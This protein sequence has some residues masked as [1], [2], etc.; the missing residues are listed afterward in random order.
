M[1]SVSLAS[2]RFE[3]GPSY[4]YNASDAGQLVDTMFNPEPTTRYVNMLPGV[5]ATDEEVQQ[6]AAAGLVRLAVSE[7]EYKFVPEASRVL[8]DVCRGQTETIS[9][10]IFKDR[11]SWDD[12]YELRGDLSN[13]MLDSASVLATRKNDAAETAGIIGA[14]VDVDEGVFIIGLANGGII[15]AA[16]TFLQLGKGD[17]ELSFVRYSRNKSQDKKPNMYPYPESRKDS[18]R[19][20]AE[21]RHVVIHDEDHASGVTLSTAVDYFA[22]LFGRAVIGI[23]PVEVDRRITYKPFVIKSE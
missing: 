2:H 14:E 6:V 16:R 12:R 10:D 17:H 7:P 5:N 8:L 3:S 23:A 13:A 11:H 19:R 21:G 4:H 20:A 9:K 22:G 18:L 1:I 15:S